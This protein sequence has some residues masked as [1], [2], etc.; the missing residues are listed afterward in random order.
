MFRLCI[1]VGLLAISSILAYGADTPIDALSEYYSSLAEG[2]AVGALKASLHGDK[3]RELVKAQARFSNA[4]IDL[5]DAAVAKF[6]DEGSKLR[7][8]SPLA[9]ILK[10]I[11]RPKMQID[12]DTALWFLNPKAPLHLKKV[13]DG[14]KVDPGRLHDKSCS[15]QDFFEIGFVPAGGEAFVLDAE[16]GG[17]FVF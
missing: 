8:P 10:G 9:E 6:G 5:G 7:V 1:T 4:F 17:R 13:D 2:D 15:Q 12:G 14:W 16:L 11:D 3:E